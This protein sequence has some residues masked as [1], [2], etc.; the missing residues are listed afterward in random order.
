MPTKVSSKKNARQIAAILKAHGCRRIVISPGSRNAP[1]ILTFNADDYFESYSVPDERSAAFTAMGMTLEKHEPAAV[2]CTS[3]SAAMNFYPAVAEAYYQKLPLI[4]ITADR[5]LELIDQGVGQTVRQEGVYGEHIV[6][7][8]KLLRDPEDELSEAYNQR[9]L[10][11]VML[12]SVNG[13]V[14]INVPFDE[15][16]YDRHSEADEEVKIIRRVPSRPSVPDISD[17]A[18][19]WNQSPRVM[20][21]AGHKRPDQ[22]L[23]GLL[24]ELNETSPFLLL[25]ETVTN[26][27]VARKISTIDRLINTISESEKKELQPDLLLTFGGEIVSK[28]VKQFIA[29]Y[30]ASEHWHLSDTGELR[31]TFRQLT[32]VIR[33]DA[34]A[35]FKALAAQAQPKA[36][37]YRNHWLQKAEA[38]A[39]SHQSFFEKAAFSDMAVFKKI[40][41]AIPDGSILHSANSAS[42]RYAQLFEH[43]PGIDHFTNRGTSGIDGCTSTA[44]GHALCTGRPVFLLTG[45]VAFLYDSNALWNDRLPANLRIIVINNQGGNIFRIIKGPQGQAEFERFQE[46]THNLNLKAIGELFDLHYDVAHSDDEFTRKLPTFISNRSSEKPAILEVITPRLDNAE[47]LFDYF[48]HV[49]KETEGK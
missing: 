26:L 9:L 38:K 32:G 4:A 20:I 34:T 43:P 6:K 1:L 2:I 22:E 42:I 45:D 3:G 46:T 19:I 28:M 5:P 7:E 21:L 16:L 17:F 41:E 36:A 14:H 15:P 23:V 29:A 30:P 35:F 24:D 10:N 18:K 47:V 33:S 40:F 39:A 49:R 25:T 44:V 31:D 8:A 37:D 48:E 12:A 13:P 27:P 11:E